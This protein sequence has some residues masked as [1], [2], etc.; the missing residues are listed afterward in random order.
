M[1]VFERVMEK[2]VRNRVTLDD[3]QFGFRPGR[4]TTDAIFTVRQVQEKFI[5]KKRDLSMAFVDL[6]KAFDRVPRD[7]LWWA[8]RQ[9]GVE[10][11]IVKV[12]QAMYEGV[13][14]S[15]RLGA[16]E[17][18]EFSVRV[19]VHQGS[20]LSPLLFII[21][22][23]E[24]GKTKVMVSRIRHGQ[25]EN[26]GKYPCG[27][28]RKGVAS[29]SIRCTKCEKWIHKRYS[30]V[31]GRLQ[32]VVEFKCVN[33]TQGKNAAAAVTVEL[34]LSA[35]EGDTLE[36]V[37]KFC[38]L[39]DMIGAGGGAEKASRMRVKCAWGKF[40]ELRPLLTTRGA[41][42]K[43]KGKIYR[44]CVQSDLMYGSETWAMKA[45]DMQRL[46]RTERMMIGLMCGVTLTDRKRSE[47]LLSRLGIEGISE[48]VRRGRLRWYGHVEHKD[49]TDWVSACR[50]LVVEGVRGRGRGRKTWQECVQED[51]KRLRLNKRDAQERAAWRVGS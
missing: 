28:C 33:C 34:K 20:V 15:M 12:I 7:V 13:T 46:E 51:M 18:E 36:C 48:V 19:G 30:K 10:E 21:V 17:T 44:A 23:E 41:S 22:L 11:W 8:L 1:K 16:G 39:G 4:G 25:A 29:N 26:S 5:A 49:P 24:L 42:L 14:T 2:R 3:M 47:K 37:N 43:L 38:Y 6:E 9:S 31:T 32:D 27:V 50:S 35:E 40:S 45:E